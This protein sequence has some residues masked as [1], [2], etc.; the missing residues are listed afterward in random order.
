MWSTGSVGSAGVGVSKMYADHRGRR[1]LQRHA[2]LSRQR[3]EGVLGARDRDRRDVRPAA[4][5]SPRP[6]GWTTFAPATPPISPTSGA[7][8]PTSSPNLAVPRK[9]TTGCGPDSGPRLRCPTARSSSSGLASTWSKATAPAKTASAF[10]AHPGMPPGA[11]GLA[12]PGADVLVLDPATGQECPRAELAA[13]G[14]ILNPAEAIGE[15]ASRTG[16]AAFEGYYKNPEASENRVHDG[17]FLERRSRLPRPG[18]LL[19]F[20]RSRRRQDPGRQRKLR[21]R[22]DRADP[23][24]DPGHRG[25]DGLPGARPAD[26]RS[27]DGDDRAGARSARSSRRTFAEAL[28]ADPDLGTKWAP[29]VR[30]GRARTCHS[31]PRPRSIAAGCAGNGGRAANRSGGGRPDRSRRRSTSR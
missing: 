28:L 30:P 27:G 26:R 9:G 7:R 22:A 17:V 5:V 29:T 18:R 10:S 4:A 31:P 13:N 6:A 23:R 20:R 2:A 24:P 3:V 11:L 21:G 12:P 1:E 25:R 19:L 8:C 14:R 15:L 16:P